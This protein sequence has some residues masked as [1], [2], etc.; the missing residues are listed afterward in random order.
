VSSHMDQKGLWVLGLYP[1]MGYSYIGDYG[2]LFY[3][4]RILMLYF[5]C[6]STDIHWVAYL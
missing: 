6:V 4:V 1:L 5:M 2:V 3:T